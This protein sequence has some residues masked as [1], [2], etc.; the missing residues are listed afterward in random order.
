MT[1]N[2]NWDKDGVYVKFRGEVTAQDLIDANNY[3]ISNA[4]FDTIKYQI[5]DFLH[6]DK[7]SI[8]SYDISIIGTM[9]KSQSEFKQ[10]MQV[11]IVTEDDY[12]AEITREYDHF[13]TGSNWT[14]KVFPKL[15]DA[16]SW[17][18]K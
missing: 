8:T 9:D 1:F 14:T 16:R 6:I 12:V 5:F 3:V 10:D 4:N 13:M 2:I 7:F 18:K 15:D 11:A 17:V